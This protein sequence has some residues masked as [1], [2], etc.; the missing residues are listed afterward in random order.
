V[1]KLLTE[2]I[3]FGAVNSEERTPI[4]ESARFDRLDC[5]KVL[6]EFDS[7]RFDYTLAFR[8][9]IGLTPTSLAIRNDSTTAVDFLLNN[10]RMTDV[11]QGMSSFKRFTAVTQS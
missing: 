4:H 2:N 5:L 3:D 1:Q 11:S 9:A 10:L 6:R 8:D 7:E